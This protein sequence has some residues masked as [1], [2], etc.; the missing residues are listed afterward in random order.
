MLY[1]C[2][3]YC[4]AYCTFYCGTSTSYPPTALL[5]YCL[6]VL[7]TAV[8]S[9][10]SSFYADPLLLHVLVMAMLTAPC[11]SSCA[12]CCTSR[13]TLYHCCTGYILYCCL[14]DCGSYRISQGTSYGCTPNCRTPCCSASYRSTSYSVVRPVSQV[15]PIAVTHVL[16]SAL[17]TSCCRCVSRNSA[18]TR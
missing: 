6:H 11:K 4:T 5:P 13:R 10:C 16:S 17:S 9:Y 12:S 7:L 15:R 18:F 8:Q 3:V 14:D 1:Y 2:T